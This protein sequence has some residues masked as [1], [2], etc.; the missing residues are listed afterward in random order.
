MAEKKAKR[1][2]R[3]RRNGFVEIANAF[4]TLLVIGI[5]VAVGVALWGAQQF[6]SDGPG[7]TEQSFL[8]ERG[9]GLET[10]ATRLEGQKLISNRFIFLLAGRALNKQS[11]IQAGEFTI[12]AKSS[13]ADILKEL[14]EGDPIAHRV[15]IPEGWTSFQVA[16]EINRDNPG[17]NGEL[18]VVPVEGTVLPGT[19][20]FFPGDTRESVLAKMQS[21]M[22]DTLAKV[23]AD[24]DPAIDDVI[25]SPEELLTLA[26]IVE[27]ETGVASERG[28]VAAV[29]LNRLRK[30][31]RLQSDPTIIYG[32]TK[33]QAPLGRGLK[34]SEIEQANDYNTYQMDGLPKGP[35]ANPGIESLRAVANPPKTDNIYFVAK[36][37]K[38][39]DGHV[40]SSTYAQ[41][42]RNVEQYRQSVA[43]AEADAARDAIDAEQAASSGDT[44]AGDTATPAP[45]Q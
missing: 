25:K 42:R 2:R 32:I 40:F 36:G 4:L 17:L 35:I 34:R 31:M 6:Y 45:A 28:Q 43:D 16:A 26:S 9:S 13:M 11:G 33:G 10:V 23:W 21:S 18:G 14:T 15:T 29:F 30:N 1:A 19:Y 24:R 8:V 39:S 37:P 3:L 44:P 12:P 7:T 38:P 27:R 22:T 20:D 5:V 41:H